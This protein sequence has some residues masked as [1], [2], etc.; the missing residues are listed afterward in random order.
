MLQTIANPVDSHM[1]EEKLR[2][3]QLNSNHIAYQPGKPTETALPY[4]VTHIHNAMKHW[5][6]A[7]EL[8]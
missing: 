1:R 8:S 5:E 4:V 2:F 7:L 3:Y 6:I